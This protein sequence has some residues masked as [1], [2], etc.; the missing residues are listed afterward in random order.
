MHQRRLPG[1]RRPHHRRQ[2]LPLDLKIDRAEGVDRGVAVA[3][4]AAEL[5]GS[6][7][8]PIRV[9]C[10]LGVGPHA[11]CCVGVHVF[12]LP[13]WRAKEPRRRSVESPYRFFDCGLYEREYGPLQSAG[14][15]RRSVLAKLCRRGRSLSLTARRVTFRATEP[16]SN[17]LR[18]ASFEP[19]CLFVTA[20]PQ[21][22]LPERRASRSRHYSSLPCRRVAGTSAASERQVTGGT[23]PAPRRR[24][25]LPSARERRHAPRLAGSRPLRAAR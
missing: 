19:G 21:P 6:N 7:D 23:R 17:R 9:R 15:A 2:L 24:R 16:S 12:V 18:P 10:N 25:G 22:H 11:R 1:P 14:R 8:G 3:V 4:A 20:Y 5:L 13:L